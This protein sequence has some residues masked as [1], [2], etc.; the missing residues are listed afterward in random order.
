LP[1]T[2][3]SLAPDGVGV[4]SHFQGGSI[5][6]SPTTGAHGVGGAIRDKWSSMGWERSFLG[7][8]TSDELAAP[9]GRVSHFQ[10]G[11][12][13][14]SAN[15]GAQVVHGAILDRYAQMGGPASPLGFPTTDELPTADGVGRYNWFS[16]GAIY[17]TPNT[18]AHAVIGA[19][20]DKWEALNWEIGGLGYPISDQSVAPNG[21]RSIDFQHGRI[22]LSADDGVAR[23]IVRIDGIPGGS[24][25]NDN[26]SCGPNSGARLLQY[27]GYN[28]SYD[29]LRSLTQADGDLIS[30]FG[31]GTR[32]GTLRDIIG[33]FYPAVQMEA[34][35]SLNYAGGGLQHVLD[36]LASGKPVIALVNVG[37]TV[38]DS[39]AG[40]YPSALHYV[41]LNGYN[42]VN[43]TISY[44]DTDGNQK[45]WSFTEFYGRWNW[46]SSG[47][48]GATLDVVVNTHERTIIY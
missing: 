28:V 17:W 34:R 7:Y 45:S 33:H 11:D 3:L 42:R 30:H 2:D 22:V 26:W 44:M 40:V 47:L 13:Y 1:I 32:P 19:I 36:L 27:Y 39:I 29:Y 9:G 24:P 10:G 43:Q 20:Y 25:Q 21:D 35:V 16:N 41:V 4:Y 18:G 12:I 6:W 46:Q 37:V 48:A 38:H 23:E 15:T 14:W 31:M 5:Y 8:P